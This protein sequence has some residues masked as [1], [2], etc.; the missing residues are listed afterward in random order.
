M[1]DPEQILKLIYDM[2]LDSQIPGLSDQFKKSP[3]GYE[4]GFNYWLKHRVMGLPRENA[5]EDEE[6]KN[7]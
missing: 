5:E 7:E 1:K 6:E 2:D 4:A 3:R